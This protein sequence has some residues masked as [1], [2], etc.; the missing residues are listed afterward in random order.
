[1]VVTSVKKISRIVPPKNKKK[2]ESKIKT[3]ECEKWV[4]ILLS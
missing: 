3:H 1:M 2:A 4:L